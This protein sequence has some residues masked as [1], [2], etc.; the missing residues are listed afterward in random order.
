MVPQA[1]LQLAG[2]VAAATIALVSIVVFGEPFRGLTI[3]GMALVILGS[4]LV[5]YSQ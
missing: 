4:A 3:A 5:L 1:Y 2:A